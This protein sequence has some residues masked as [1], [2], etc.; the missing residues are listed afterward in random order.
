MLSGRVLNEKINTSLISS[1]IITAADRYFVDPEGHL[2]A[3]SDSQQ[4][5]SSASHKVWKQVGGK[6][7]LAL[8]GSDRIHLL[9]VPSTVVS[10]VSSR[11]RQIKAG[12]VITR[13]DTLFLM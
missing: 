12:L 4:P 9:T 13:S 6:T 2:E 11:I 1:H 8:K 5:V 3:R 10:A 7:S